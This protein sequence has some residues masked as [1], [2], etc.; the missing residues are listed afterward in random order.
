MTCFETKTDCRFCRENGL[1]AD[2]PVAVTQQFFVLASRDPKLP[3]AA[4]VIPHRH[5]RDPFSI[6]S[7]EWADM[8]AALNAAKAYVAQF[9]PAGYTMGWNVGT[10]G[11]QTV[12]HVHLHVIARR[13]DDQ[14]T[15]QG[16][17]LFLKDRLGR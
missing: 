17:R 11:G 3:E 12:D 7:A 6:T 16:L 13:D 15:G 1:L 4:M 5:H 14:A 9:G 8:P 10:H 2:K